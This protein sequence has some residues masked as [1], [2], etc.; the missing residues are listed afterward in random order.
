MWCASLWYLELLDAEL[1][2]VL[3]GTGQ[4]VVEGI[5]IFILHL[6]PLHLLLNDFLHVG[7][8]DFSGFNPLNR[9]HPKMSLL[10][11]HHLLY[12]VID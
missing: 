11:Y 12:E 5:A 2:A 8:Q 3:L 7:V 4:H 10:V 1:M 9:E 6:L